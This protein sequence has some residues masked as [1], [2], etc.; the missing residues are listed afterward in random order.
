[1]TVLYFGSVGVLGLDH[2]L[3][4]SSRSSVD[5]LGLDRYLA[6]SWARDPV[7]TGFVPGEAALIGSWSSGG[8]K[9]GLAVAFR[10]KTAVPRHRS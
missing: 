6:R 7:E 10:P 2:Y 5:V 8:S 1:M 3:V 9:T 4:R